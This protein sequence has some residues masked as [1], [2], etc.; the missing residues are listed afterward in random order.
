MTYALLLL[1]LGLA[2]IIAET[3]IPSF[4]VLG[5][6]A[7]ISILAGAYVAFRTDMDTGLY[8]L[9]IAG[10]LIPISVLT[11]F[12][13]LPRSPLAKVLMASGPSF[14]DGRAVDPRD[15]S[16]LGEEGVVEAQLR[17]AGVA[18]LAGRRVDVVSRGS[19]IE[20]GTRV[21]VVELQGN[22]VVVAAVDP[23]HPSSNDPQD[24]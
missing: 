4:G 5:T 22:R 16:L 2:L 23:S 21:R 20:A 8:Y 6:L 7:T 15:Q 11:G 14:E 12:R 18:R 1:G 9:M 24:A 13:Y 19:L 17:P 10:V 3:I